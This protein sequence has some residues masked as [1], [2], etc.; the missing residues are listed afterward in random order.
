MLN[1]CLLDGQT[2]QWDQE[3]ATSRGHFSEQPALSPGLCVGL[4]VG[5]TDHI[6]SSN[7][8]LGV[9]SLEI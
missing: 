4:C 6:I 5:Q 1:E 8:W 9:V 7:S 2:H 3:L